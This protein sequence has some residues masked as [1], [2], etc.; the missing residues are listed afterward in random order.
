MQGHC[1]RSNYQTRLLELRSK[2][3]PNPFLH[4]TEDLHVILLHHLHE[5]W[6]KVTRGFL[7]L[8][9]HGGMGAYL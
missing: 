6:S 8:G 4:R 7:L 5:S 2:Y 1:H 3:L 9:T